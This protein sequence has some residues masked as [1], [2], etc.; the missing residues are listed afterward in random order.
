MSPSAQKKQ[1]PTG[2][3]LSEGFGKRLVMFQENI[4][5]EKNQNTEA[6]SCAGKT[7]VRYMEWRKSDTLPTKIQDISDFVRN[8]CDRF[9]REDI[10]S[11]HLETVVWLCFGIERLNPFDGKRLEEYSDAYLV[12]YILTN[13]GLYEEI[14]KERK[15][16]PLDV[17]KKKKEL[18]MTKITQSRYSED[19]KVFKLSDEDKKFIGDILEL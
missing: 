15:I 18:A 2:S 9:G 5:F 7:Y 12:N 11:A 3:D 8:A 16:N 13:M 17:S 6:A 14:V 19:G 1:A 10:A 4:G